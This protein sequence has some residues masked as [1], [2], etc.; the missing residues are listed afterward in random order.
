[1][2]YRR[3]QAVLRFLVEHGV[4]ESR[5]QAVGFGDLAPTDRAHDEVTRSRNRRIEFVVADGPSGAAP[6][7]PAGVWTSETPATT[8]LPA[9]PR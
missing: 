6:P 2:S 8:E 4:A 3:A 1:M 7:P 9:A 5:L